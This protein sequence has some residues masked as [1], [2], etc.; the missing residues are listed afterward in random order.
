MEVLILLI[1]VVK[2]ARSAIIKAPHFQ[3]LQAWRI[4]SLMEDK[5]KIFGTKD[6]FCKEA[7][8]AS[9]SAIR[10]ITGISMA[11]ELSTKTPKKTGNCSYIEAKTYIPS[12]DQNRKINTLLNQR[13]G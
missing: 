11:I 13:G 5:A 12:L 4:N 3:K 7:T 10:L 6:G 1:T 9:K 2:E 8:P